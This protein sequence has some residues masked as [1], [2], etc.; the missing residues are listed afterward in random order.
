MYDFLKLHQF[1]VR[2][3]SESKRQDASS[4]SVQMLYAVEEP[5]KVSL[6]VICGKMNERNC[7]WAMPPGW[8]FS[9]NKFTVEEKMWRKF[10]SIHTCH[11]LHEKPQSLGAS[12]ADDP[13]CRTEAPNQQ[14]SSLSHLYPWLT[15]KKKA[16]VVANRQ[17][18]RS[19]TCAF[20]YL[21]R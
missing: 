17:W 12:P 18:G 7:H 5:L 4:F 3:Y 10:W 6:G 15:P 16:Q 8:G 2:C 21:S 9:N 13:T 1:L 14:R 19:S 11:H 20:V